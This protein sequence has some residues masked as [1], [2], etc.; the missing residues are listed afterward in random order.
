[1]SNKEPTQVYRVTVSVDIKVAGGN[2][3]GRRISAEEY[4][5]RL[6]CYPLYEG[7][8]PEAQGIGWHGVDYV[9]GIET[10]EPAPYQ[11]DNDLYN[12]T[13]KSV[14]K[15]GPIKYEDNSNRWISE[16]EE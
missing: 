9:N 11:F 3:R 14:R 12:V 4:V 16:E 2:D 6:I 5:Q 13:L 1:M 7:E 10:G 8:G 15:V